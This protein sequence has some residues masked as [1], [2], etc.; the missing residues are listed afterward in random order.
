MTQEMRDEIAKVHLLGK[1]PHIH[2]QEGYVDEYKF[3]ISREVKKRI[4][5]A[6]NEVY[7]KHDIQE[8]ET[9]KRYPDKMKKSFKEFQESL[10]DIFPQK[11]KK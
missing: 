3:D 5:E 7:N 2:L 9:K 6:I 11:N 4:F 8:E 10:N 1:K